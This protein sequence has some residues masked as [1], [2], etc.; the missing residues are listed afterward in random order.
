MS[1]S[2]GIVNTWETGHLEV[3]VTRSMHKIEINIY[4]ITEDCSSEAGSV[5][6][7]GLLRAAAGL[8]KAATGILGIAGGILEAAERILKVTEGVLQVV[9]GYCET[10]RRP[11]A[12]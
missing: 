2:I 3:L 8:L 9:G 10:H 11:R 6:R 1:L 4:L 5:G 7:R 12:R